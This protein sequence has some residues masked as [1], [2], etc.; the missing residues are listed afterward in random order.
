MKNYIWLNPVVSDSY[1]IKILEKI[2][3]NFGFK[4]VTPLKNHLEI[5]KGEYKDLLS[6]EKKTILDMRCPMIVDYFAYHKLDV[7]FPKIE[8]ILI[9]VSRELEK[10]E[11]LKDG[12]KW[13]ITPCISLKKM[14]NDLNLEN[15]I[16]LTFD[17]LYNFLDLNIQ[18]NKL[19]NSPIPFGF[20][21][22]IEK[23]TCKISKENLN[24]LSLKNVRLIEGLYCKNGCHNGDGVKCIKKD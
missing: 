13:I 8:P 7:K 14:G 11:D 15:T 9:H 22:N 20:F 4:I 17:E 12:I 23:N 10:R 19:D 3:N 5:V 18:G 1:N 24:N 21:D 16:F 6:K 2:L